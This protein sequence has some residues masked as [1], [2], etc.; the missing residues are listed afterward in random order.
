VLSSAEI[1]CGL[2]G[3]DRGGDAVEFGCPVAG[4]DRVQ[5]S[6]VDDEVAA[7]AVDCE[8]HGAAR[9]AHRRISGPPSLAYFHTGRIGNGPTEA[10][11]LLINKILRGGHGFR[12][13]HNHFGSGCCCT[14][15]IGWQHH[16]PHRYRADGTR[17]TNREPHS[18]V[19]FLIMKARSQAMKRNQRRKMLVLGQLS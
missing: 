4:E 13:F 16:G 14:A 18:G 5:V 9:L 12:N 7:S 1:D 10:I 17:P 15:E 8:P 2:A 3:E 6:V 11:N 19:W